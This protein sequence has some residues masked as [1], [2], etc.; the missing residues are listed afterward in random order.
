MVRRILLVLW[1][2]IPA[3][4][5]LAAPPHAADGWRARVDQAMTLMGHRNWILVVDSAYPL[6]VSPG[7]ETIDTNSGETEVLQYVLHAIDR[8]IQVRPDIFMDSELPYLSD[9]DAPGA[10][11]YRTD[12][13]AL[14]RGYAVRSQ[15]HAALI[16]DVDEAGKTFHVLILKTTLTVP[17]SSVSSGSTASIGAT[18]PRRGS[19]KE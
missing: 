13:A 4:S 7:I 17:Y 16:A 9:Q 10:S 14:L 3:A 6:Q 12:I 19:G 5:T 18:R 8:S 15:P 1:L 11:A 2:L